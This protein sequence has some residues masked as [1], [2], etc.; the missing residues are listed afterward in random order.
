M[1][2]RGFLTKEHGRT[3]HELRFLGNEAPHELKVP[4]SDE[5]HIAIDIVEHT[6]ENLYELGTK[7]ETL[8]MR[9]RVGPRHGAL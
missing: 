2:E 3:L 7:A 9:K 8:R 6:L 1:I 4:R 5:L